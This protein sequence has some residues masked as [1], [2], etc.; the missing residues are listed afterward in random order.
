MNQDLTREFQGKKI[1]I[2]GLGTNNRML[3]DF[4]NKNGIVFQVFENW[5]DPGELIG[6]F[7]DF[8]FVFRTPGLPYL[9]KAIQQ[10]KEKGVVITSQTNLFFKLCTA[11]IIG[12]TGTKGKGTTSSLIARIL[13]KS[14]KKV[15]LG[16]NIGKDPFEFLDQIKLEDFVVLELSSFQLQDLDKSPFIAVVLNITLDHLNHHKS[17]DEYINAK[18][19]ILVHQS[20]EDFAVLHPSLPDWFRILG[21]GKKILFDPKSV[22]SM[23]TKLLGRHNFENIAAAVE[24]AK[25]LGVD[26]QTIVSTVGEFEALPHRLKFVKEIN[27]VKFIDDGFSTNIDPTIAAIDAIEGGI[28]LIVGGYDK[29]L[30]FS[31]LGKKIVESKKI[32]GLIVIGQVADK[33]FE[34]V[35]EFKGKVL[36]GAKNIEE[37]INQAQSLAQSGD[38]IL[39]S[40]AT[41][42]FGMFKNETDRAEQ[43]V[44]FVNKL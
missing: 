25:I 34:A 22:S 2:A 9:S 8:D 1:A 13:E 21:N 19:Q 27:G 14:G 29:G 42:S 43:F 15:W 6:K 37:I 17:L 23:K 16:G 32:K 20:K 28:I 30:D 7:D 41:A 11:K 36:T 10:A 33:I 35:K 4:F 3:A 44:E 26:E 38:T 5:S 39:F 40:P 24:T 31:E 12:I 18:S